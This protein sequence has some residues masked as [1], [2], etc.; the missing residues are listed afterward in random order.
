MIPIVSV[1]GRSSSGKTTLLE[2]LVRELTR[3]GVRIGTVKHHVHGPVEVDVP[4][5][6]S[7]RHKQAGAR[8]VA[9]ASADTCFVVR[10]A[11]EHPSLE[12]I[13]HRYLTGVDLILS[14]GF[15]AGAMPKIEVNRA[16]LGQP[17]LCGPEDDLV[18][19]VSDRDTGAAVPHFGLEDTPALADF[20]ETRFL[21][22]SAADPLDLLIG[23][24]RIPLDPGTAEILV[25]VVW[26]LVGDHPTPTPTGTVELRIP[27]H[28]P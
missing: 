18:A 27:G 21:R 26:S 13:A 2:K 25:R 12:T 14:E 6:D 20:L 17:L 24:R 16:A 11:P 28:A 8:A 5:K 22:P 7:W 9:L 1:I 19:V 23:G 4:G 10:D 3:R 15:R